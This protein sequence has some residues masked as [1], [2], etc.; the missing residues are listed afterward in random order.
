MPL[1]PGVDKL[2]PIRVKVR[3]ALFNRN[4][5]DKLYPITDISISPTVILLSMISEHTD[6]FWMAPT[7]RRYRPP[8]FCSTIFTT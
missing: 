2:Y 6:R 3:R 4:S 5:V 1:P 8:G 7:R